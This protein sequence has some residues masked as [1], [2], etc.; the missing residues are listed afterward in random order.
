MGIENGEHCYYAWHA[1]KAEEKSSW[2]ST[3]IIQGFLLKFLWF[4]WFQFRLGVHRFF[5]DLAP[6]VILVSMVPSIECSQ[7]L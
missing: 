6:L 2:K 3:V 4:S 5:I 7:F 1:L